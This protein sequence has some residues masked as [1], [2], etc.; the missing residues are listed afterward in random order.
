MDPAVIGLI[1]IV[2]LGIFLVI[3]LH[4]GVA[5][6]LIGVIGIAAISGLEPSV[7]FAATIA[8]SLAS[9]YNLVVLPLFVVMGLLAALLP[10]R[11]VGHLDPA[12]VFRK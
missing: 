6:G 7:K 3:G 8:T 9:G 12:R 10:A 11:Y 4:I 1:G 5:L 2:A